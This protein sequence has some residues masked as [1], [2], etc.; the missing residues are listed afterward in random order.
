M[1]VEVLTY[2]VSLFLGVCTGLAFALGLQVAH[3]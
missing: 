1:T 2:C 3:D